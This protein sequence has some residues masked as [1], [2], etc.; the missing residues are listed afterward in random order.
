MVSFFV[1]KK[2]NSLKYIN[3]TLKLHRLPLAAHLP[4]TKRLLHKTSGPAAI[5]CCI[6][7]RGGDGLKDACRR[8]QKEMRLM[9]DG[10][11][12]AFG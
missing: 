1:N 4:F 10:T 7:R 6:Q 12:T 9:Q 5:A 8:R 3:I 2:L 11:E